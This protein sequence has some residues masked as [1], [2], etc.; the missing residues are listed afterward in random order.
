MVAHVEIPADGAVEGVLLAMGTAL[1]G[2]SFHVLDGKL[3]YAHNYVGRSCS[4]VES[5]EVLSPGAHHLA[6]SF[7]TAGDFT[8]TVTLLVDG[9][10]V[11]EGPIDRLTPVR[12]SIT[13]GGITCGWEQGPSVGPG[14]DAPFR[15]TGT[16]RR[17][18]VDT[19]GAPYRDLQAEFEAIMSE[20]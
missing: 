13:G 15:F 12:H 16:L 11:G 2:W 5:A 3:R 6:M 1:G 14:Y 8:A 9:R 17:V 18:V 4:V 7:S 19:T 20:Q 10:V